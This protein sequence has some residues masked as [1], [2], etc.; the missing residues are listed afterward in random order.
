VKFLVLEYIEGVRL[1][2][3]LKAAKDPRIFRKVPLSFGDRVNLCF[4]L[5]KTIEYLHLRCNPDFTLLH[6]D[7]KP[8]NIILSNQGELKL[9]D[10]G[11]STLV[12]KSALQTKEKFQMTGGT[13]TIRYTAPEVV[14]HESYNQSVDVYS[15]SLICWEI[16]TLEFPFDGL[17]L[18]TFAQVVVIEGMRPKCPSTW[19]KELS[20]L[21]ESGWSQNADNRPSFDAIVALLSTMI[22]NK[23]KNVPAI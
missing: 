1:S 8:D 14:I 15:F 5:A 4:Q 19:S 9:L 18:Q 13:G 16:L 10:F 20:A 6:R 21:L 11:L 23:P 17:N 12:P 22:Q 3:R 2:E 7:L